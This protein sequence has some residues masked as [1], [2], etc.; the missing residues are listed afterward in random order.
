MSQTIDSPAGSV[1]QEVPGPRVPTESVP[2]AVAA[3]PEPAPVGDP[4]VIGLPAFLVGAI[5]LALVLVGFVPPAAGAASIPIIMSATSVGLLIATIWAAR[6]GQNAVAGVYGAFAGFWLSYAALVLGLGHNWFA[7]ATGAAA[8]SQE[9]FLIA[10]LV[11]FAL[12]TLGGLRLPAVYPVLFALVVVVIVLVLVG[13]SAPS[14]AALKTA[15]YVL[16]VII[17]MGAYLFV[18]S[19]STAT[20][21]RALPLGPP[22]LK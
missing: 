5:A 16:F 9:L 12:L 15:G 7:I 18:N 2:E 21:G 22:I 6:L 17:A 11:I 20:G 10:W 4:G 8:R 14:V 1:T 13:T 19:M 3:A